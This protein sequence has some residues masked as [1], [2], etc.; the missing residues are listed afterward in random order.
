MLAVKSTS[1][2]RKYVDSQMVSE[3]VS[4]SRNDNSTLSWKNCGKQS[5]GMCEQ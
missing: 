5:G 4:E 3:M 1:V 2:L